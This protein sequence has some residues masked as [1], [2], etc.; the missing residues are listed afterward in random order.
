[1][2]GKG[3]GSG[4][5]GKIGKSGGVNQ[6]SKPQGKKY[7]A[8]ESS[9]GGKM[10]PK[11]GQTKKRRYYK[12][13]ITGK[14]MPKKAFM[15][16]VELAKDLARDDDT[17]DDDEDE[18]EEKEGGENDEEE[19]G[20]E[21]SQEDDQE[22]VE[23]EERS[24]DAVGHVAA[25]EEFEDDMSAV[26]EG[27]GGTWDD[28]ATTTLVQEYLREKLTPGG[29]TVSNGA[30]KNAG[31]TNVKDA[32]KKA[33]AGTEPKGKPYEM[34]QLQSKMNNLKKQFRIA[35]AIRA[36]SSGWGPSDDSEFGCEKSVADAYLVAHPE[37]K[38]FLTRKFPYFDEFQ[39]IYGY[40]S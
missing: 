38:I 37:A 4:K 40:V 27:K 26:E 28:Q 39:Q 23:E 22:E 17:D 13:P 10:D 20:E 14:Y 25:D 34:K 30:L 6:G 24:S 2:S 1:M 33:L 12:G 8:E 7:A 19:D 15:L 9:G 11:K 29:M 5:G 32:V 3:K 18:E 31:W 16:E 35:A 36:N 21:D